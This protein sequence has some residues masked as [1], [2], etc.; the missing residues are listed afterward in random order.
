[1]TEALVATV[2][3]A[4]AVIV[5]VGMFLRFMA[6]ERAADRDTWGNHLADTVRALQRISDRLDTLQK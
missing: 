1:M 3:A 5:V 6:K 2:P 4:A